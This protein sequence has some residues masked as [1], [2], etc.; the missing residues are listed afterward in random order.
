MPDMP[1]FVFTAVELEI[2]PSGRCTRGA[3][4]QYKREL[5]ENINICLQI[6]ELKNTGDMFYENYLVRYD[7]FESYALHFRLLHNVVGEPE[8]YSLPYTV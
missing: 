6:L 4:S 3:I 8:L 1:W 7:A 2:R 5:L